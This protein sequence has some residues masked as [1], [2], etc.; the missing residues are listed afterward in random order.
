[1]V[2]TAGNL[3]DGTYAPLV[4]AKR[5]AEQYPRLKKMFGDHTYKNKTLDRWMQDQQVPYTLEIRMKPKE[6]P[7]FKPLKVRWVVEQ[8]HACHGRCRRL[9]KD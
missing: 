9:S 7:V 4:L 6:E 5:K 8:A 3:D 2:V 1:V